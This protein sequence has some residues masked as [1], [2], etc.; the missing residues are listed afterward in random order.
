[1]VKIED[2]IISD[3]EMDIFKEIKHYREMKVDK[4]WIINKYKD[5]EIDPDLLHDM[6]YKIYIK[7]Y[8]YNKD[9]A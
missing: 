7:K 6:V 9:G 2:Y 8:S 5:E 1:M 4:K 3:Y